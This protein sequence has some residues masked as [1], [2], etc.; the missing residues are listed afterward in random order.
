MKIIGCR[1]QAIRVTDFASVPMYAVPLGVIA[2]GAILVAALLGE[3][4]E[5]FT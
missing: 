2:A 1:A 5:Y 4:K 3:F